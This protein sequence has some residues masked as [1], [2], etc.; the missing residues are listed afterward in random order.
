M[1]YAGQPMRV[2]K[3]NRALLKKSRSFRELRKSYVKFSGDTKLEFK[4][5]SEFEKK[6]I[7]DKIIA[8][9]KKDKQQEILI[10]GISICL[11]F[12]IIYGIYW[13][14]LS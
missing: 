11:S 5:L 10:F 6:K 8:Q 9:S 2:V 7:R 4:E 3:A 14:V 1:G 13:W 12:G